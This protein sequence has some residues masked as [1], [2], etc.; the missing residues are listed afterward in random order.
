MPARWPA[1]SSAVELWKLAHGVRQSTGG[2]LGLPICIGIIVGRLGCFFA[3][4]PDYTYGVPSSLP[5]AVDL[6]DGVGR[7]PV[8]L[9]E[10]LS[11]AAFLAVYLRARSNNAAWARNHAFHA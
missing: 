10:S 4:L 5:W 3:G 8:Q 7:H 11:M 6:G 1:G 2:A 9:Y